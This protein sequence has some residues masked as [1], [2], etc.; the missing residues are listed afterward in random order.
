[1]FQYFSDNEYQRAFDHFEGIRQKIASL[2]RELTP[3]AGGQ[4]LDLLAG[5][6]YLS[7]ELAQVFPECVIH[8]TGLKSDY[9]T[10][11]AL[12]RSGYYPE[13]VWRNIKYEECDVTSLPFD[14][15][16]FNLV[17]N[18][19]GL[20]DIM[21]TSGESGL[22]S[23]I[24]EVSRVT[25]SK[26]LAEITVVEYGD[27]PEEQIAE[28]VWSN[29]GL[30]AVFKEKEFYIREFERHGLLPAQEVVFQVRKKMTY[31]QAEEELRFACEEAPRIFSDYEVTAVDFDDLMAS[32]GQR[33]REHGMAF[34]PNVRII[35]FEKE[36]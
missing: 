12:K 23:V 34:Y 17:A 30:N 28:E 15:G 21:M 5:H 14:S 24:S 4:V 7:V 32:Y 1:M 20:E 3:Q 2:L 27:A 25:D 9:D 19:L 22:R 8:S 13:S 10:F 26:G 11:L 31:E 18:F 29:I 16:Y 35:I 6:G 36:Y 33:I